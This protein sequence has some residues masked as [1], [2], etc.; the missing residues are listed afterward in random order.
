MWCSWVGVMW[1]R[2]WRALG[3]CRWGRKWGWWL[4]WGL[5]GCGVGLGLPGVGWVGAAFVFV[6]VIRTSIFS[7]GGM[8]TSGSLSKPMA[9][10]ALMYWYVKGADI[11]AAWVLSVVLASAVV[12][13]LI[14]G[15]QFWVFDAVRSGG[16]GNP[17]MYS[18]VATIVACLSFYWAIYT[19][20]RWRFWLF[21]AMLCAGTGVVFSGTRT[22]W[23][24]L[25]V[26]IVVIVKGKMLLITTGARRVSVVL[27]LVLAAVTLLVA[28]KVRFKDRITILRGNHESR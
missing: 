25:T 6:G 1:W 18:T 24:A 13:G 5:F 28:L 4:G 22:A 26:S 15:V 10:C 12:I 17:I 21:L 11:P 19:P 8:R 16:S 3:V 23:V 20:G 9:L 2:S 14:S 27:A 7:E